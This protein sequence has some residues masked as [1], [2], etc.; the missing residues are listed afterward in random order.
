MRISDWSS[1]VCSS[2]LR[3]V[4]GYG[5]TTA[6]CDPHEISNVLG[7]D[8][9]RYFLESARNVVMD[10]R[11]QL[12]SCVPATHLETSGARLEIADLT[13]FMD[14]PKVLGLA[15]FMNFPGVLAGDPGRLA[16]LE[17]FAGRHI[18]GHAPLLRG[19]DL[20]GYLARSEEHT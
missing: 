6:I 20:N 1:D 5:L 10:V 16:K 9:I 11:V 3:C 13:P 2:D 8:G 17:A 15:E 19:L 14:D 18:D 12:S 4:L 7:A